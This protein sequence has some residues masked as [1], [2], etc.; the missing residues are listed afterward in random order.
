MSKSKITRREFLK[1]SGKVT[2]GLAA[3]ALL[4]YEYTQLETKW[5][6]YSKITL[7]IPNL[8]VEFDGYTIAHLTDIHFDE[9]ISPKYFERIVAK[10]NS[11]N[12]DLIAITGDIIDTRTPLDFDPM[13][14]NVLDELQ[15]KDLVCASPGNHDHWEGIKRFNK[16]LADSKVSVLANQLTTIW[17]G[18]TPL[19]ICGADSLM[20]GKANLAEIIAQLPKDSSAILLAHEPDLALQSAP[21][22]KFA[23]QL[24]GHTHGG[25]VNLPFF[26]PP[27]IPA[28][29]TEYPEGL[30]DLEGMYLYTSRGVGTGFYQVRF[31]CRPEVPIITLKSEG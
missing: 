21:T 13:I 29:G 11:F 30:Y 31:N 12:P 18:E 6:D 20:V 2:A 9:R 14:S 10:V 16:I 25:L 4:G 7:Q 23:L 3:S 24:S 5:V 22:G 8:P 17:R 15:A 28:Y 26:G 1:F 27:V 19:Y